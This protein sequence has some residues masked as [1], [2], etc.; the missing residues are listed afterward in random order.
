[1]L[2]STTM[3][4]HSQSWYL[5]SGQHQGLGERPL[6]TQY[7]RPILF[8]RQLATLLSKASPSIQES[9]SGGPQGDQPQPHPAIC[10]ASENRPGREE[11]WPGLCVSPVSVWRTAHVLGRAGPRAQECPLCF[12]QG[13]GQCWMPLSCVTLPSRGPVLS[14]P[15][16]PQPKLRG[17]G[18]EGG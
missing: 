11:V 10:S 2:S 13:W 18:G 8:P 5:D 9:W 6:P 12:C 15:R 3:E 7:C 16:E 17:N 4:T 14:V 1:M